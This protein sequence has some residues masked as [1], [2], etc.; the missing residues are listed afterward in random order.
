MAV[1]WTMKR[2]NK[3]DQGEDQEQEDKEGSI[4][5][6]EFVNSDLVNYTTVAYCGSCGRGAG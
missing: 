5:L 6:L 4:H 1:V 2:A 3:G